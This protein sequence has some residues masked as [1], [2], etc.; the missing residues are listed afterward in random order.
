MPRAADEYDVVVARLNSSPE[1][2]QARQA[3][4]S[5][6]ERQRAE[7]FF[8]DR[9]RRRFIAARAR[10][11]ELLGERL[12]VPPASVELAYGRNGK[13]RLTRGGLH[14]NLSHC[15]DVALFGFSSCEI[16][17]DIEA[18]RAGESP[19]FLRRWTRYE[20][21]AKAIGG[22][23][24]MPLEVLDAARAAGWRLH[25]FFPLPGFIAAVARHPA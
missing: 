1:D 2:S 6:A 12:G 13:P 18:L 21:L 19:A 16:G 10:L 24:G 7:Q 9:D 11:R 15:E 17:V 4:L 3:V 25:S 20:A 14:F 23:L 22:G 5:A 8:F